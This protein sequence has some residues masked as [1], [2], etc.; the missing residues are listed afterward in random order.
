MLNIDKQQYIY[1]C[2]F[3][4]ILWREMILTADMLLPFTFSIFVATG[5][6]KW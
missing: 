1:V 5:S 3:D 2:H 6:V 4:T